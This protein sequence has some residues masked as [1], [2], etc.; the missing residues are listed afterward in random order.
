MQFVRYFRRKL[1]IIPV[2]L[3]TIL[4]AV[5][6]LWI[7]FLSF[8][9]N[10]EIVNSSMSIPNFT[11]IKNYIDAWN[12]VNVLQIFGNTIF[13]ATITLCMELIFCIMS[14]Y[15]IARFKSNFRKSQE[16]FY[17]FFISGLVIPIFI[18][19]FPIYLITIKLGIQDTY[20]SLALPYVAGSVSFNTLLLV[21]SLKNFPNEIEEAAIIDGCNLLDIIVKIVLP[22]VKPV[23]ATM[24]VFNFLGVWNEFPLASIL[25]NKNEMWTVALSL[26]KFRGLY[27]INYAATAAYIVIIVVPQLIFYSFFQKYIIEGMTAGAV[28]G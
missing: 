10:N 21:G 26:S 9:T 17:T 8:K 22:V 2:L 11:N 1:I 18:L 14:S 27:S 23:I 16:F 13:V 25:L 5:P 24:I 3:I 19:I 15:G 12:T 7:L 4:V 6:L 20:L 28:K